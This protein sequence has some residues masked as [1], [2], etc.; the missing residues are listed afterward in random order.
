MLIYAL[1]M[2]AAAVP[3]FLIGAAL[4]RGRADLIMEHHQTNVKDKT[5]Y[6]RAFRIPMFLI[7]V[8]MVLSGL[9]A[10][11]RIPEISAWGSLGTLTLGL[12]AAIVWIVGIQ[13]K[14]DRR[15]A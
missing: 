5:A 6:A 14:Y 15:S 4:G 9:L 11:T 12:T 7:A 1:I 13:L 8:S 3:F 2:F 10:L